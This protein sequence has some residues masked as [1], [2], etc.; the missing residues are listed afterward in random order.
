MKTV[1]DAVPEFV[2]ALKAE[3]ARPDTVTW[4]ADILR[5]LCRSCGALGVSD[6]TPGHLRE[7]FASCWERGLARESVRSYHRALSRFWHWCEVEYR[8]SVNP[9]RNI[10]RPKKAQR[11]NRGI[12]PADWLKLFEAARLKSKFPERDMF[13]LAL[14]IDTG[15]RRGEVE[16][17]TLDNLDLSLCRAYV[18]GKGGH[19]RHVFFTREVARLGWRWLSARPYTADKHVFVSMQPGHEPTGL[20]GSGIYQ[21]FR[22]LKKAAGVTGRANPHSLRHTWAK[23]FLLHGGDIHV[24]AELAGWQT[25]EMARE[26]INFK[27]SELQKL[28]RENSPLAAIFADVS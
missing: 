5:M 28:H 20:T 7:W 4:Y 12:T 11:K 8:L 10:K 25:L 19:S 1:N 3:G 6:I 16:T 23:L 27:E 24:L 22:R 21:V 26:Y 14:F 18:T 13:L 15:C 9:M 17:L 2:L